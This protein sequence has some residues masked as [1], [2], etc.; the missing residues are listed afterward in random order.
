RVLGQA[1]NADDVARSADL[2]RTYGR[3]TRGTFHVL[4]HAALTFASVA[5]AVLGWLASAL[6]WLAGAL[7]S[8]WIVFRWGLK[9]LRPPAAV[10]TGGLS[11]PRTPRGYL[12]KG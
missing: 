12:E 1:D 8:V 4:G 10:T 6:L 7:W 3:G 9:K 11:A 5:W 2:A